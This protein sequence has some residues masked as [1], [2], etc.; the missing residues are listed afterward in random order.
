M[1]ATVVSSIREASTS[2]SSRRL[3]G[4]TVGSI[5]SEGCIDRRGFGRFDDRG[6]VE[7]RANDFATGS[8]DSGARERRLKET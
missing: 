7:F 1:C 6:V 5:R 8:D 4:A 2:Y 3:L